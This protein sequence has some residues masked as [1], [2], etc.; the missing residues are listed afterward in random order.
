MPPRSKKTIAPKKT[1]ERKSKASE[2]VS[3]SDSDDVPIAQKTPN[4]RSSGR[5][6]VVETPKSTRSS[7]SSQKAT[8]SGKRKRLSR[9]NS[10]SSSSESGEEMNTALSKTPQK[11]RQSNGS[12]ENNGSSSSSKAVRVNHLKG[13]EVEK[14]VEHEGDGSARLYRIRWKGYGADSDTWEPKSKLDCSKLLAKYFLEVNTI[15]DRSKI[16][17]P[18]RHIQFEQRNFSFTFTDLPQYLRRIR[19]VRTKVFLS[20]YTLPIELE[21]LGHKCEA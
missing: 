18:L 9:G 15:F 4:R 20:K 13:Y 3:A 16:S 11:K 1:A 12:S 8:D 5:Q 10:S 14:I 6:P 2:D 21:V 17:W 19:F 7:R